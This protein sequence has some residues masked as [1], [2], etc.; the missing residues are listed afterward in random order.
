[1]WNWLT[2]RRNDLSGNRNIIFAKPRFGGVFALR[3]GT[4]PVLQK[5][6]DGFP[7]P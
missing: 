5:Q 1:M 7:S 2:V 4:S 6:G 3:R